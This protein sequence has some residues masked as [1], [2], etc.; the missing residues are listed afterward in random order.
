MEVNLQLS[1][2]YD[3][4]INDLELYIVRQAKGHDARSFHLLRSIPGIGKILSLIILYEA[5]DISRFDRVQD[6]VSY[7]RLVKCPRELS[8]IM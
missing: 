5:H 6:F 3:R 1:E 7:C 8:P 4:L 2:L